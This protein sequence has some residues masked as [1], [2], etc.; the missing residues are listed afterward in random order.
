MSKYNTG[1][2]R[3]NS[4]RHP[5][6]DYSSEGAYFIT[7]CTKN[8]TH[9]FG[10]IIDSEMHLSEIGKIAEKEWLKTIEMRSDMNLKLG[11]FIVM[12]DH[13]H[14]IVFFNGNEADALH[15]VQNNPNKFGPQSKNLASII[16]GFKSA[17]KTYASKNNIEF[18]WQSRYHDHIIRDLFQLD[19]I[20]K[21][22]NQNP[23]HWK[24]NK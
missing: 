24:I 6:W 13:F 2:Y 10:E 21:Y 22:I 5:K 20:S 8:R 19:R 7:I 3:D 14:G 12:P 15:C 1:K 11:E 17:V 9:Y 23:Q 4:M 16:R 18:A